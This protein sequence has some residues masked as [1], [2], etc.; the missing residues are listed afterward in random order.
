MSNQRTQRERW[1][2][3]AAIA[4]AVL[5]GA[6]IFFPLFQSNRA[7]TTP[8]TPTDIPQPTLPPPVTDFSG[9]SFDQRYL[10]PSGLYTVAQPTGFEATNPNNNGQIVQVNMRNT[11]TLAVIETLVEYP[12]QPIADLD[13]LSAR[14][15]QSFLENSWRSYTSWTETNRRVD[16]ENNR[17]VI[18]FN[19]TQTRQNFIGRHVAWLNEDGQVYMVRVVTPENSRDYLL[20]LLDQMIPTIDTVDAYSSSPVGWNS[21]FS[22]DEG[23]IVRYPQTWLVT[24][25]SVGTP[26]TVE[27]E[28]SVL[29]LESVADTTITD[30]DA[31]EAY[32][33]SAR[34]N[35]EILSVE[36]VERDGA[37]GF[38]VAYSETN[39]D[40][41]V[42]S[43]QTL[44]LNDSA[45]GRLLTANVRVNESGVDFNALAETV[46]LSPFV[47]TA[48]DV[49]ASFRVAAP[50]NLPVPAAETEET[51][52]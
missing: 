3:I 4:L 17:V 21:F 10:H 46:E 22:A 38:A 2:Y 39:L 29:R 41:D 33:K 26:I 37:S 13:A 35:A 45:T 24:D 20:H 36:P 49:L 16:T 5:M 18:D 50:L 31:A 7:L 6:S 42:F 15:D 8:V 19:L 25:G 23:Y 12:P 30:A 44:L 9:I 28:E 47:Q 11:D 34:P 48:A 52:G 43:G 1:Y 40:G 14:L 27:G 32:V 51:I